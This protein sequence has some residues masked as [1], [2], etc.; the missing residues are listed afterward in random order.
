MKGKSKSKKIIEAVNPKI[1]IEN[2]YKKYKS[3]ESYND[4]KIFTRNL[5]SK[6]NVPK[7]NIG[8]ISPTNY[9]N[10][11][12]KTNSNYIN[13]NTNNKL[14]KKLTLKLKN[15]L[16]TSNSIT[17][18]Y[19]NMITP[20]SL[21]SNNNNTKTNKKTSEKNTKRYYSKNEKTTNLNNLK[22]SN[23]N[24]IEIDEVNCEKKFNFNDDLILFHQKVSSNDISLEKEICNTKDNNEINSNKDH[25]NDLEKINE[26]E[27]NKNLNLDF[28]ALKNANNFYTNSICEASVS[29]IEK[30]DKNL[31][32][33]VPVS[34]VRQNENKLLQNTSSKKL[35]K[36]NNYKSNNENVTK[37]IHKNG[38]ETTIIKN[39]F[40]YTD[41]CFEDKMISKENNVECESNITNI[42][43]ENMSND[44]KVFDSFNK[45]Y[46]NYQNTPKREYEK[47]NFSYESNENKIDFKNPFNK[48][49]NKNRM[50]ILPTDLNSALELKR[51]LSYE[52]IELNKFKTDSKSSNY[53]DI[54]EDLS[55][56]EKCNRNLLNYSKKGDKES[57][58][59]ILSEL[60][61]L[62]G[63]NLN[64]HVFNDIGENCLHIACKEGNLK[65]VEILLELNFDYELK[66]KNKH[67]KKT[68]LHIS[69]ENGYFDISKMLI[70]KGANIDSLDAELNTP[71]HL[72][73]IENHI[74]LFQYLL[75][76]TNKIDKKNSKGETAVDLALNNQ[77][78]INIVNRFKKIINDYYYKIYQNNKHLEKNI[79][80]NYLPSPRKFDKV[81]NQYN[82]VN[83]DSNNNN[84]DKLSQ[85]IPFINKSDFKQQKIFNLENKNNKNL[86]YSNRKSSKE[87][88]CNSKLYN[89]FN[90]VNTSNMISDLSTNPI[91]LSKKD[92]SNRSDLLFSN[93]KSNFDNYKNHNQKISNKN[94]TNL[95]NPK[96]H[97]SNNNLSNMKSENIEDINDIKKISNESNRKIKTINFTIKDLTNSCN[98]NSKVSKK[99][100]NSSS[101]NNLNSISV[102]SKSKKMESLVDNFSSE[103][104]NL[105]NTHSNVN[106]DSRYFIDKIVGKNSHNENRRLNVS[107]FICHMIL[108]K[109]SFGEVY[110]VEEKISRVFYAMKVLKKEKMIGKTL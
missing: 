85:F 60:Y 33:N 73:A 79:L 110:L 31:I 21:R 62:E 63:K 46:D 92:S 7:Q 61:A 1:S 86:K 43:E 58:L 30:G 87:L 103:M 98:S 54:L 82:N 18:N 59:E 105:S 25:S 17:N 88:S 97:L 38:S 11:T 19:S 57:F 9:N 94:N 104:N 53:K 71:L 74:E 77:K 91:N 90:S 39:N 68:A 99:T 27:R 75:D 29:F 102:S 37:I 20:N 51:N 12:N 52:I 26:N 13:T 23:E 95:S 8:N 6:I 56:T 24:T 5:N 28:E 108:G 42:K 22:L 89:N 41:N 109:G 76:K 48:T 84:K 78:D 93:C 36:I 67:S 4:F 47:I 16:E 64:I 49:D 66:D 15:V 81:K 14:S 45:K 40:I 55:P 35:I 10:L 96:I 34:F 80:N 106:E 44:N 32:N 50:N 69:C 100:D 83:T 70:E 107:D 72:C 101:S 2:M 3:Q 65:I